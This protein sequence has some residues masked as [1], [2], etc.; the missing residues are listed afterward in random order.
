VRIYRVYAGAL[1]CF[2]LA[3]TGEK[4]EAED[5]TG[6]VFTAAIEHLPTFTDQPA[7]FSLW[8]FDLARR[9]LEDFWRAGPPD[10]DRAGQ[11]GDGIGLSYAQ[12]IRA[13]TQLSDEQREV[14]FLRVAG[15]KVSEVALIVRKKPGAVRQLQRR[16]LTALVCSLRLP[17]AARRGRT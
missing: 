1:F 5:L 17:E 2:F 6:R 12:V 4:R 14:L 9:D 7:A 8:L 10:Q 13:A 3:A 15:L 11:A 16:A